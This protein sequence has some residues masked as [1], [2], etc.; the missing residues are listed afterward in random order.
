MAVPWA[1]RPSS[2]SI[3]RVWGSTGVQRLSLLPP[4]HTSARTPRPAIESR[5]ELLRVRY[6]RS[7]IALLE[8]HGAAAAGAAST[9][10]SV[11]PPAVAA[12]AAAAAHGSGG[13]SSSNSTSFNGSSGGM[14]VV[15]A[16]RTPTRSSLGAYAL[17]AVRG[18]EQQQGYCGGDARG[19]ILAV[20][21]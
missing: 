8:G 12:A 13:S 18:I 11:V 17:S 14:W 16:W 6:V 9:A 5:T 10:T 15:R 3:S 20:V 1:Q 2:S 19:L 7:Y 4:A 21:W